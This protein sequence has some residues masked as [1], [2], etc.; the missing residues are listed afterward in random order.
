[1]NSGRISFK[2]SGILELLKKEGLDKERKPNG[3]RECYRTNI[4]KE[5]SNLTVHKDQRE[6]TPL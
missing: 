6:A 1:M 4:Q 2:T 3:R 5:L